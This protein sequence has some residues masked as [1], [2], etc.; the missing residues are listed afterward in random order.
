MNTFTYLPFRGAPYVRWV[1]NF[2][3]VSRFDIWKFFT[4]ILCGMLCTWLELY[5]VVLNV[6]ELVRRFPTQ[7]VT[8]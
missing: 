7:V 4:F 2:D 6:F 8:N 5:D 3:K 1:A